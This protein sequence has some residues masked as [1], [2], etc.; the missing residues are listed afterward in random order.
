M[1][2]TQDVE[3]RVDTVIDRIK[4][5]LTE[6]AFQLLVHEE[7]PN[8][9][10]D[11]ETLQTIAVAATG[12]QDHKET[13]TKLHGFLST[14]HSD[15]VEARARFYLGQAFYL[16]GQYREALIEFIFARGILYLE[17]QPWIDVC[18]EKLYS[19]N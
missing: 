2:L 18:L 5:P 3:K 16:R 14:R 8:L 11:D 1:K 12:S 9:E 13:V 17:T 6:P 4:L 7:A 19:V 10:G 15:G